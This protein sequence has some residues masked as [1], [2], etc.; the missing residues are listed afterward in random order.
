MG[1][2]HGHPPPNSK[3]AFSLGIGL[4]LG[5]VVAEV[6]CGVGANSIA[7]LS[8]AGHNA[9]DVLGLLTAWGATHIAKSLP[10]KRRTY[11]LRR[12][13]ILAALANGGFLFLAVGAMLWAAIQRIAAPEPVSGGTVIIVAAAGVVVNAVSASLFIAGSKRDLNI[14]AAF[15]HLAADAA[16]SFGVGVTGLAV[17][18]TGW[19]WLD[20]CVG[21]LI[22]IVIVWTTWKLLRESMNLAMDAVPASIEPEAVE[23]FLSELSGVQ[24][25]HDLHIWGMS[26][27]EVALTVH[28]VMPQLPCDDG[29]M[30]EVTREL[31][32]RFQICHTTIQ[33][34]RGNRDCGQSAEDVV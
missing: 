34:E 25:V 13:T 14:R 27:T 29:F 31:R 17:L 10:T 15:L 7:L 4:N 11:G 12:F 26:T 19:L 24:T 18:A 28:I 5:F 3:I 21:I 33:I 30:E 32:R 23:R 20:P 9:I 8:D 1:H 22:G 16:V 6:A 2:D